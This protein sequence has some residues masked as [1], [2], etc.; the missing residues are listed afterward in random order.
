M[1]KQVPAQMGVLRQS[2]VECRACPLR[3]SA[4]VEVT[5]VF[6]RLAHPGS[7]VEPEKIRIVIVG[8]APGPTENKTGR[9]FVGPSGDILARLMMIAGIDSKTV[10]ITNAVACWP[11]DEGRGGRPI[12]I[13][14]PRHSIQ[15]CSGLH[16]DAQLAVFGNAK[17]I[18]ADP[19]RAGPRRGGRPRTARPG[20]AG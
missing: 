11:H 18:V 13:E 14:P 6:G 5:P 19:R 4:F 16:L 8:E 20:W 17:V 7:E 2:C 12:T 3:Q 1:V 9:P 15:V 10:W